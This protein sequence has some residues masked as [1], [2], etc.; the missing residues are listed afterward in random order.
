MNTQ[1]KNNPV[2]CLRSA[3]ILPPA[4]DDVSGDF[5]LPD[6]MPDIARVLRVRAAAVP[7]GYYA[8]DTLE[9]E[10]RVMWNVLYQSEENTLKSVSYTAAYEG[11]VHSDAICDDAV[12]SVCPREESSAC[13]MLNPRKLSLRAKIMS[14]IIVSCPVCAD[15]RITTPHTVEDE[16]NLERDTTPLTSTALGFIMSGEQRVSDSFELDPSHSAAAEIITSDAVV[17]IPECKCSQGRCDLRGEVLLDVICEGVDSALYAVSRKIPFSL[18][19]DMPDAAVSA[20]ETITRASVSQLSV[21]V[22]KNSYGEDRMLDCDLVCQAEVVCARAVT[23]D[24]TRDVYSTE[25]EC[26]G[27]SRSVPLL[28]LKKTQSISF[29]VN[30]SSVR[31]EIGAEGASAILSTSARAVVSGFAL[32]T[33]RSRL[34]ASGTLEIQLVAQREKSGGA[35]GAEYF[36]VNYTAPFKCELD[37]GGISA[38]EKLTCIPVCAVTSAKGRL[39]STSV[40]GDFEISLSVMTF[41]GGETELITGVTLDKTKPASGAGAPITLYYPAHGERIWDIAKKYHVTCHAISELNL[42]GDRKTVDAQTKVLVIPKSRSKSVYS[43]II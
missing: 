15:S 23:S 24:I 42:L 25:Y 19:L 27:E 43:A 17:I 18:T 10:G 9:Y 7:G 5:I 11:S 31:S 33:E 1:E 28:T 6:Y 36:P 40:Y 39:D 29:S 37:G 38:S 20:A 34:S 41:T 13:R 32:D 35:E 14:D 4:T 8:G 26:M 16:V 30:S 2:Q 21:T 22:S 12:I 3:Y